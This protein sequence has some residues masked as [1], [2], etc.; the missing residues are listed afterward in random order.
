[1]TAEASETC[2]VSGWRGDGEAGSSYLDLADYPWLISDHLKTPLNRVQGAVMTIC[3][4]N[5]FAASCKGKVSV[6]MIPG[7]WKDSVATESKWNI[8]SGTEDIIDQ[9]QEDCEG[10]SFEYETGKDWIKFELLMVSYLSWL[11]F[12]TFHLYSSTYFSQNSKKGLN[13]RVGARFKGAPWFTHQL[14]P[15]SVPETKWVSFMKSPYIPVRKLCSRF[16]TAA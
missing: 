7:A 13:Q 3:S 15:D 10:G 16:T 9:G 2:R 14:V 12:L 1:M 8:F 6:P 5:P 4:W 11:L